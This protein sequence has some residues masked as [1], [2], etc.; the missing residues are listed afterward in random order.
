[1][2]SATVV[3]ATSPSE[4]SLVVF[5]SDGAGKPRASWFDAVSADFA[6]K[7]ADVMK[8]RVFKIETDEQTALAPHLAR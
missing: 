1:M 8:M 3:H 7:A 4:P 2:S 6:T 5:G